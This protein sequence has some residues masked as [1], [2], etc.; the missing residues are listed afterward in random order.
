MKC[1]AVGHLWI[2]FIL[3]AA[4]IAMRLICRSMVHY[5][6]VTCPRELHSNFVL[7]IVAIHRKA[8]SRFWIGTSENTASYRGR[9]QRYTAVVTNAYDIATT[10]ADI[11]TTGAKVAIATTCL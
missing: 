7:N 4:Q 9:N 1:V 2:T 10:N 5:Q 8:V 11:G 6:R 3:V